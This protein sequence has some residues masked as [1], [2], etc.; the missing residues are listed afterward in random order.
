[1]VTLIQIM[2]VL[3]PLIRTIKSGL[4]PIK[5]TFT[6]ENFLFW[7]QTNVNAGRCVE[8]VNK[9]QPDSTGIS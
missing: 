1:M 3:T 9:W 7:M 8:V 2:T 5:S 6:N 4:S